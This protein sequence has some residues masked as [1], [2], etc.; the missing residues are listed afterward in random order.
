MVKL[1]CWFTVGALNAKSCWTFEQWLKQTYIGLFASS[2]SNF[3]KIF[4]YV[5]FEQGTAQFVSWCQVLPIIRPCLDVR[6]RFGPRNDL[7]RGR[8]Q[9]FMTNVFCS[10]FCVVICSF[11]FLAFVRFTGR[12]GHQEAGCLG[13]NDVA[14]F[15]EFFAYFFTVGLNEAFRR[16][17]AV[18]VGESDLSNSLRVALKLQWNLQSDIMEF[19]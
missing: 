8:V 3:T 1:D 13:K 7:E 18:M 5:W 15:L 10:I 17:G 4:C 16:P 12:I 9:K 14:L 6:P 19:H 11:A 2:S